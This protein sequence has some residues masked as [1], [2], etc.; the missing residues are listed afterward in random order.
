MTYKGK[1]YPFN[2]EGFGGCIN[3]SAVIDFASIADAALEESQVTVTGA[4][5][6]D[7]VVVTCG[8][9]QIGLVLSGYV[10]AADTVEVVASNLTGGAVNLAS[11]TFLIKVFAM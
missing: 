4:A 7:F 9:D 10:S 6:G 8:I 5:L 1:I 3:A 11:A 2:E